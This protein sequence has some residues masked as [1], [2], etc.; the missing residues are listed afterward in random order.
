MRQ[1]QLR[2]AC[3]ANATRK[4]KQRVGWHGGLV[5]HFTRVQ[6]LDKIYDA[7]L[8]LTSSYLW[9]PT[10]NPS[11]FTR[12]A[13]RSRRAP[14]CAATAQAKILEFPKR[15]PPICTNTARIPPPR[16]AHK[17]RHP[18]REPS[19]L[20]LVV[21]FW[22]VCRLELK[23]C[24]LTRN[25]RDGPRFQSGNVLPRPAADI[26]E[27]AAI[28]KARVLPAGSQRPTS[29]PK[30]T[31]PAVA[32]VAPLRRGVY[33]AYCACAVATRPAGAYARPER[34]PN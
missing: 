22:S 3:G 2:M 20:S 28:L 25:T 6:Q 18:L 34:A 21:H 10:T 17:H 11:R 24:R 1:I 13:Q 30:H 31:L 19:G 4:M 7:F 29:A 8:L 32:C 16:H 12:V 27:A 33:V 15:R 5:I 14:E 26:A 23:R 9:S